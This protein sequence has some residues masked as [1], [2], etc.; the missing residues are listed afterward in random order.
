[1]LVGG[2]TAPPRD[3]TSASWKTIEYRGVQVDVPAAWQR[4][5]MSRCEL[6]FERWAPPKTPACDYAQGAAF[7]GSATFDPAY[8][9]GLRKI[10]GSRWGGWVYAGDYAVHV[11]IPD[12]T[13]AQTVLNSARATQRR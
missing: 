1:M 10:D 4:V 7:Y 2:T 12:R 13:V 9:A 3:A 5:D 6:Q 11:N 8:P